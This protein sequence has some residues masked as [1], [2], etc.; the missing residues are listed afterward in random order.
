M[1]AIFSAEYQNYWAIAMATALWF[2][3]RNMIWVMT[4]RRAVSK[5]G[6]DAVDEAERERLKRRA[7]VTAA[8]ICIIFSFGYM[9]V[10]FQP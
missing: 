4:V 8:L 5:G 1:D 7:G 10:L 2:P 6:E 9:N 3:A